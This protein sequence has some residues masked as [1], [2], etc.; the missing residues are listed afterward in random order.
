[1]KIYIRCKTLS[2]PV[3]APC[4]RGLYAPQ[5]HLALLLH[6]PDMCETVHV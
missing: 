6:C 4:Q 1:M 5:F 3:Q 2:R